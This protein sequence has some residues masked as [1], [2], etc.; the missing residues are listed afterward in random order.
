MIGAGGRG[1]GGRQGDLR[2]RSNTSAGKT[3]SRRENVEQSYNMCVM[4]R[5]EGTV[6]RFG[7]RADGRLALLRGGVAEPKWMVDNYSSRRGA[8]RRQCGRSAG[9]GTPRFARARR[10]RAHVT[11]PGRQT[12]CVSLVILVSSALAHGTRNTR[13]HSRTQVDTAI[14]DPSSARYIYCAVYTR[15]TTSSIK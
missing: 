7:G 14:F 5:R 15:T 10:R 2:K 6:R 3:V 8:T 12:K 4:C 9:R 11:C 13:R 1:D